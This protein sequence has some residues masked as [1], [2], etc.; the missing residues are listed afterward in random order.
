MSCGF[1]SDEE[2]FSLLKSLADNLGQAA[3]SGNL[4]Q[5]IGF[6]VSSMGLIPPPPSSSDESWKEVMSPLSIYPLSHMLSLVDSF[7]LFCLRRP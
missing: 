5:S 7:L 4:S 6:N 3:V 2:D 1:I